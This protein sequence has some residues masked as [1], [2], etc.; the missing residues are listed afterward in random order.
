MEHRIYIVSLFCFNVKHDV[1][2]VNSGPFGQSSG[3]LRNIVSLFCFNV[4]HDVLLI[5]VLLDNLL[6]D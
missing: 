3:R 6:A 4:K 2:W 5:L 1:L